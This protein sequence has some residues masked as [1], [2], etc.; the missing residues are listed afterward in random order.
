MSFELRA[1]SIEA[2]LHS[3]MDELLFYKDSDGLSSSR[4]AEGGLRF[5]R[6]PR[7]MQAVTEGSTIRSIALSW[8]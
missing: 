4:S 3:I 5:L 1:E 8:T 6:R 7:A 2:L